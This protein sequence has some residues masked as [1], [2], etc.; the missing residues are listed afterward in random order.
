MAP[1]SDDTPKT[2]LA[3]V[4]RKPKGPAQLLLENVPTPALKASHA[5]IQMKAVGLNRS[6]IFTGQ[7]CSPGVVLPRILG[8]ECVGEVMD[9]VASH[10]HLQPGD[11][12]ATAMG[13]FGRD[14]DGG[15]AQYALAPSHRSRSWRSV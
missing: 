15:Y 7:D 5:V 1:R 9:V 10:S 4:L 8:I 2:M 3:E 6:E 11:V 14:F 12:V 13:G